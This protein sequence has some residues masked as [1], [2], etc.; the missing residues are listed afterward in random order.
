MEVHNWWGKAIPLTGRACP[1]WHNFY[2]YE[3]WRPIVHA[4]PSTSDCRENTT[5]I[6]NKY[7]IH[8]C[9]KYKFTLQQILKNIINEQWVQLLKGHGRMRIGECFSLWSE[10]ELGVVGTPEATPATLLRIVHFLGWDWRVFLP[11]ATPATLLRIVHF[12]G[13][14]MWVDSSKASSWAKSR[15]EVLLD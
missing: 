14:L 4:A 3:I 6:P 9:N 1:Y 10:C 12:L 15:S 2:L 7:N 11:V 13:W 8:L 5:P